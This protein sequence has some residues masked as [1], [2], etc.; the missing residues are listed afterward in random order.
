V[1]IF[2]DTEFIEKPC[3]IELIS[4]G[5]VSEDNRKLYLESSDVDLSDVDP[6]LAENVLP[7]LEGRGIPRTEIRN[8]VLEF[9]GDDLSPEF[10]CYFAAY[11]WVVFCW[12]FGRMVDLPRHFPMFC[13]DF[14]QTMET[15]GIKR[16]ELPAKP[17]NCHNALADAEWLKRAYEMSLGVSS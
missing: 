1:K 10:I 14:K 7:H 9:V 5:M 4:I 3:S 11:D 15:H 6:W 2:L 13:R 16:H 8:K 12:L 17:K